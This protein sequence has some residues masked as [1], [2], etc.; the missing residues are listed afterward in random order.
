MKRYK[1]TYYI[2]FEGYATQMKEHLHG[3]WV[4]HE[5]AEELYEVVRHLLAFRGSIVPDSV[6][7][8]AEEALQKARGEGE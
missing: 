8:M 3:E 5:T 2:D 7:E 4:K 1:L 6:F